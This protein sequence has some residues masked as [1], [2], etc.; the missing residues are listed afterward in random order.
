MQA[1]TSIAQ[2]ENLS[3]SGSEG[4]G[5][6]PEI[7]PHPPPPPDGFLARASEEQ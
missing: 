7:L 1:L 3:L 6:N 2:V 4:A 5:R